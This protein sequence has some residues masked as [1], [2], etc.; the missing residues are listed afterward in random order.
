[1]ERLGAPKEGT[2]KN[3]GRTSSTEG[4]PFILSFFFL[5]HYHP[6]IEFE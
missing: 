3:K 4:P 6:L 5:S 2:E 1:M